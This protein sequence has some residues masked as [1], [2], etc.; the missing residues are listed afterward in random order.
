MQLF[1]D[2]VLIGDKGIHS[3]R[4]WHSKNLKNIYIKDYLGQEEKKMACSYIF[5]YN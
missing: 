3:M 2:F 4:Q 5:K 1:T